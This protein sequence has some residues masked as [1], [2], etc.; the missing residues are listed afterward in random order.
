MDQ[1]LGQLPDPGS[2]LFPFISCRITRIRTTVLW[3]WMDLFYHPFRKDKTN[4][5]NVDDCGVL[6]VLSWYLHGQTEENLRKDG[7]PAKILNLPYLIV[8]LISFRRLQGLYVHTK[9]VPGR[10]KLTQHSHCEYARTCMRVCMYI[11]MVRML[12]LY[13]Y[14]IYIFLIIFHYICRQCCQV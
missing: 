7:S 4:N 6:K 14:K 11:C 3:P 12:L 10:K 8:L 9:R 2:F 1:I 5:L 13:L